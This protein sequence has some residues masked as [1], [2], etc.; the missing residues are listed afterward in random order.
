LPEPSLIRL[1]LLRL[2]YLVLLVGLGLQHWPLLL[3][4]ITTRSASGA[5]VISMLSA[6]GLLSA[7]GL[8]AP[9]RMLPILLWEIV[10]KVTWLVAVALPTWRAGEI[11]A[12]FRSDLFAISL[13][14]PYILI[15]PWRYFAGQI[16][17]HR[18]RWR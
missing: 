10:W 15:F 6:L 7:I 4:E 17:A 1:Y 9:L 13:V 12:D 14:A 16:A 5:T 18:D 2:G 11:D 8:I 3:G